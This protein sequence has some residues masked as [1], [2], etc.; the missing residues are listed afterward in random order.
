MRLLAV[1]VN[2]CVTL[3]KSLHLSGSS[4]VKAEPGSSILGFLGEHLGVWWW[5]SGCGHTR[6]SPFILPTVITNR[7]GGCQ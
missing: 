2:N 5:Q 4:L 3:D 6:V 1:L 7:L